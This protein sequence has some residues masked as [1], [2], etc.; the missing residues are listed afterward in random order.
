MRAG[1]SEQTRDRREGVALLLK[2]Q[3]AKAGGGGLGVMVRGG[4][5]EAEGMSLEPHIHREQVVRT[6][7]P[8]MLGQLVAKENLPAEI[9]GDGARKF[10]SVIRM[11]HDEAVR[12]SAVAQEPFCHVSR[13]LGKPFTTI[14][15]K[16]ESSFSCLSEPS[17]LRRSI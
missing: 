7:R 4:D 12:L 17:C 11:G 15:N 1:G 16:H 2:R 14:H 9:D 5:D 10:H 8:E 3:G 13:Q 6:Q